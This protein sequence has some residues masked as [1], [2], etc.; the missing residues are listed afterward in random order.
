MYTCVAGIPN[1]IQNFW[2]Y[3]IFSTVLFVQN[4]IF[5][6]VGPIEYNFEEIIKIHNT[7]VGRYF[8]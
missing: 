6:E 3:K 5:Y 7:K 4:V 2:L 1:H 8:S